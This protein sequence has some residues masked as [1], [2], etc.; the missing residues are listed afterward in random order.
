MLTKSVSY[1]NE[2]LAPRLQIFAK[3]LHCCL[4]K[5]AKKNHLR[6]CEQRGLRQR[7]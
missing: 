4:G 3:N 7:E 5:R 2:K 1:R 6:I